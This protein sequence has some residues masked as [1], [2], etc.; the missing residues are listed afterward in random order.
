MKTSLCV[1]ALS[2]LLFVPAAFAQEEGA[3]AKKGKGKGKANAAQS[4]SAQLLKQLE[5]AALTDD[6]TA[7]I[8]EIGKK[9]EEEIKK[10]QADAELTPELLKKR[11]DAMTAMKDSDKKGKEKVKAID[12]EAGLS[13]AQAAAFAKATALRTKLKT[14]ALKLLSDE[15]KAKLPAEFTA[16][17]GGKAGDQAEGK[18]GKGK[19]KKKDQ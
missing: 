7:K 6:Q 5:P 18:K 14:E 9:L 3:S 17:Q 4:A 16:P 12:A 15:Q 1:V 8:K 2:A 19:G 10:I 13:E 11:R